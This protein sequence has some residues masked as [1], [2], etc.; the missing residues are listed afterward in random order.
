MYMNLVKE[1]SIWTSAI[2]KQFK[3]DRVADGVVYYHNIDT[4]Q[5]YSCLEGAFVDRFLMI[6]NQG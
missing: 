4:E 2:G 3:V 6:D 1:K 5:K